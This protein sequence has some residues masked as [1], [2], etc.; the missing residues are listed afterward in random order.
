[1]AE[2]PTVATPTTTPEVARAL[3]DIEA[4]KDGAEPAVVECLTAIADLVQ[5]TGD[6]VSVF[7]SVLDAFAREEIRVLAAAHSVRLYAT[8][9]DPV[10]SAYSAD[11]FVV[12][13]ADGTGIAAIPRG[14]KPTEALAQ[15][16]GFIHDRQEQTRLAADFQASVA[17]GHVEDVET[18]YARTA[19]AAE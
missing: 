5:Q 17:A 8:T 2:L 14:Q 11:T 10:T 9:T 3:A 6:P 12:W 19:Q 13:Q 7:D 18:W 16:R 1:M 4:V 15:L